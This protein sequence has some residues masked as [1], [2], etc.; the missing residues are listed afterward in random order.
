MKLW[1]IYTVEYYSTPK[2]NKIMKFSGKR[3]DLKKTI[4]R[5]SRPIKTRATCSISPAVSSSKSSD[6]VV[7]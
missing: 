7:R 6:E 4:L 1:N 3:M 2:K 5:Q